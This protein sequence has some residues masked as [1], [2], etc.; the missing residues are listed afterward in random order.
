M[1]GTG[2][3]SAHTLCKQTASDEMNE[4]TEWAIIILE[5]CMNK[6]CTSEHVTM[7][8][9]TL[10]KQTI[11]LRSEML[12]YNDNLFLTLMMSVHNVRYTKTEVKTPLLM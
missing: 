4:F 10:R 5:H 8:L 12:W 7:V 6:W 3:M 9:P 2:G 11:Y 1:D